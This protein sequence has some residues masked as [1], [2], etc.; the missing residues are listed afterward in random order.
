VNY[1][2]QVGIARRAGQTCELG[3]QILCLKV[4]S[5]DALSVRRTDCLM[6]FA[7][8]KCVRR[9]RNDPTKPDT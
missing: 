5:R 6:S 3:S 9:N 8:V 2:R 7:D 1:G 4:D